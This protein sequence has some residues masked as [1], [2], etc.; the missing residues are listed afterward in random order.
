MRKPQ[1]GQL[2]EC[3]VNTQILVC[4]LNNRCSG[5]SK[6]S[7]KGIVVWLEDI[8]EISVTAVETEVHNLSL[9][10][11]EGS[12]NTTGYPLSQMVTS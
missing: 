11:L 1:K 8:G 5:N 2:L 3:H 10:K 4:L 6:N 9:I 12:V 7:L